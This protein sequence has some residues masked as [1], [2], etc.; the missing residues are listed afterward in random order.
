M[1]TY[2]NPLDLGYRYQH[3]KEGERVAG[4]REGADPTLVYF[5]NKYYLFVSM[6][7]GFWYSDDLLHWDF[8]ADPDLQIY[9]Y[10]PDVR[11]V[12]DYLYFSASAKGRNCPILRTADPLTEP[13]TQVSAP[14]DFW[15]PIC[16]AMMMAAC[17]FTGAAPTCPPSGASS[18]TRRR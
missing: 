16:S 18:W 13:F 8:H 3:M 9:D 1:K 7:A 2:C 14:F 17:I 5:K 12:G 15:D 10:A 6:S 11:Q 4:F